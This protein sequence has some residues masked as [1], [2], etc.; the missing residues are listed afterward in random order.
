M[1]ELEGAPDKATVHCERYKRMREG[2]F[3]HV[4]KIGEHNIDV[5]RPYDT[6]FLCMDGGEIKES[7]LN[8]CEDEGSVCIDVGMGIYREGEKL[9]GII[10]T[11]TSEPDQRAH[12]RAKNRI[13][14]AG[15]DGGEYDR[16]IQ[17]VELNAF[18]RGFGGD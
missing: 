6:I 10:R 2:L 1:E 5:L 17:I 18:E 13:D 11:T 4:A 16:N 9:G 12:I 8:L 14:M 3:A 15:A 7:I